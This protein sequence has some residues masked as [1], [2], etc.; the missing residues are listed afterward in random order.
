MAALVDPRAGIEL[1]EEVKPEWFTGR[2]RLIAE[3]MQ[4]AIDAGEPF[5][6][7]ALVTRLREAGS[8]EECGGAAWIASL[9]TTVPAAVSIEFAAKKIREAAQRRVGIQALGEALMGLYSQPDFETAMSGAEAVLNS[10]GGGTT[11]NGPSPMIDIAVDFA[12]HLDQ[13]HQSGKPPGVPSGFYDLD[14]VLSNFQPGGL[15]TVGARPGMGK[16][17]FG[18]NLAENAARDGFPTVLFSLEMTERQIAARLVAKWAKID[19]QL[20]HKGGPFSKEEWKRI[21]EA[22]SALSCFP[23]HIDDSSALTAQQIAR[24]ARRAIREHGTRL[25]VVDYLQLVR[26]DGRAERKDLEI[27]NITATMKALAKGS[28]VPVVLLSQLNREVDRRE[29]KRPVLSD[30]RESGAIEQDSDAVLFL[31]RDEY[32]NPKTSEP[33]VA[34]VN[35]AKN[36]QGQNRRVKL[37][38]I[39]WKTTFENCLPN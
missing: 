30:L 38:W 36:R 10:L 19:L 23:L 9:E 5:D 37:T 22:L 32:Y 18:C 25:V 1:F 20:L 17:A 35:V 29:N 26:G 28:D 24:R 12:D 27:G 3:Q 15:Y 7:A 16:S 21:H 11:E 39:G 2:N 34:E 13:I 6:L 4:A 8:L 31:Y 14:K 33:G